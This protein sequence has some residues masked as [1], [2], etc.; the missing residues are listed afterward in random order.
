MNPP[1]RSWP[2]ALVWMTAV[3]VPALV[4]SGVQPYD[5]LTWTLE[6]L[7][8]VLVLP[9]LALTRSRFPLTLLLYWLIGLHCLV[10]DAGTCITYE[11]LD[12]TGNYFGGSI[13][14][15]L[16]MPRNVLPPFGKYIAGW[17]KPS[18]PAQPPVKCAGGAAPLISKT[19]T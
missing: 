2:R 13:S 4:L 8:V 11:W 15:G 3:V 17:R 10:I 9:L 5:R 18:A 16:E 19:H 7:P 6:V 12:R 1:V 14:P